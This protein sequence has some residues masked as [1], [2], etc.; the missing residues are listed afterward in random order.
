MRA[1]LRA[2]ISTGN[3]GL[4]STLAINAQSFGTRSTLRTDEE[5]R[6][7]RQ[8][9]LAPTSLLPVDEVRQAR[10]EV[11]HDLSLPPG[12]SGRRLLERRCSN[13]K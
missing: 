12:I 1:P 8:V 2:L 4:P 11:C 5:Q 7:E 6:R 3:H 9:L 13:A 10:D